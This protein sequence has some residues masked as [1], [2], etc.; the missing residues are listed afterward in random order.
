MHILKCLPPE[1]ISPNLIK[2]ALEVA[3]QFIEN[4]IFKKLIC[5]FK[6]KES[7]ILVAYYVNNKEMYTGKGIVHFN[8]FL[9]CF[10]LSVFCN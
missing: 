5:L 9:F 4:L 1:D 8:T 10:L 3:K 7:C 6:S 2:D